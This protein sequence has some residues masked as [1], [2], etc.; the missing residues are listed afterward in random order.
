MKKLKKEDLIFFRNLEKYLI[1]KKKIIY[2]RKY[3]EN[4]LKKENI[5]IKCLVKLSMY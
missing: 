2:L 1:S 5:T 3:I 4:N